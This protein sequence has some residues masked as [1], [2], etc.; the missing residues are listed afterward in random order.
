[1]LVAVK[2]CSYC[3]KKNDEGAARCHECGTSFDMPHESRVSTGFRSIGALP[4]ALL[5][6]V[7]VV[8]VHDAEASLA[9]WD[10]R[11]NALLA[12]SFPPAFVVSSL[13]IG[14]IS[15]FVIRPNV[16]QGIDRWVAF[17]GC[18]VFFSIAAIVFLPKLAE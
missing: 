2:P 17:I 5:V 6:P 12:G 11:H 14:L 8:L 16:A 3:G 7:L 4:Y 15:F 1:M 10:W 18:V 9:G 13:I